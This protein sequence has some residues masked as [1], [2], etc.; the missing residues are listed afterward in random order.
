MARE[1]VSSAIHTREDGVRG[2][3]ILDV[4]GETFAKLNPKEMIHNPVM[5]VVEVGTLVTLWLTLST[6]STSSRVYDGLV[7]VVLFVTILF[8]TFA[9]AYAE[10]RGRAQAESLKRNR[11]SLRGKVLNANGTWNWV[12][13]PLLNKGMHVLVEVQDT[14]PGDGVVVDGIGAMDESV[15]TGESASVIKAP[16]DA[17]TGGT[18]LLS[19]RLVVE[20]THEPG[21]TFLDR[22][23]AL[24]EGA[25]RQKT[26]NEIAL[27]ALLGVLTFIFLL[28]VVTLGPITHY[29]GKHVVNTTT[30]VALLVCLI[31]TTIGALLSAIGIAGMN[32]VAKI[33]VV[34]K[35]GR[36]VEAAGDVDTLILDK[37][38]TITVGNRM[39]THFRPMPG[40]SMEEVAH[41][42]L[43]SSMGD[44]TPE[45]RSIVELA[46]KVL[47][48]DRMGDV[49]GE[50][51]PFSANTRMSGID[52]SNGQ[53]VR[54]GAVSAIKL[55][56]HDVPDEL[57]SNAEDVAIQGGTPLA[58]ARDTE[59]L[60]I[61]VLQDV[62]KPG[63]KARFSQFR[64]MGIR[65]VMATGDNRITASVI[66]QEAG[67]DEFVAEVNPEAKLKLIRQEQK[68]GRLVAMTGDGTNDAPA[69]AQA[70]VGLAMNTGTM[71]AKEAGNM[72]D[73]ESNPTKLL[74]VIMVGKQLLITR[75]ALTTFSVANDVAKYFAII[76]AMFATVPILRGLSGLNIMGLKTPH[77]AIL[78]ALIFNALIIPVLIPFAVRGVRYQPQSADR[79]L[80]RN[81][82]NWGV[83]GVIIPF[84]GIWAIDHFLGI[85]GLA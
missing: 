45:G 74:D 28:V 47:G 83:L 5:F 39:A 49:E 50:V 7:T 68:E 15:I 79:L 18:V 51:V 76:P 33:N 56:L 6:S 1:M 37:T 29:Y 61:I 48:T 58:I 44:T 77:G 80:A 35:S 25:E 52:L 9:E 13:A 19:D 70:D 82:F 11:A 75:G 20:I 2:Y 71:A 84:I 66:A 10:A 8:A 62:V 4:L 14:M 63:L 36:A 21:K 55:L 26:P 40:I 53:V 3:R 60:G 38:G 65:T 27:S 72:L 30:L 69:L 73:L 54:K 57:E 12:D 32:R 23:I 16:G 81:I 42:A 24:V 46:Q 78:S 22:M 31:P 85:F 17:V 64:T 43:I 41:F 34:A 59:A 67:V